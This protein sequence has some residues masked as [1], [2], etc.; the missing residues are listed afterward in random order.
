MVYFP[1]IF[2]S[3]L[4]LFQAMPLAAFGFVYIGFLSFVQS[5]DMHRFAIPVHAIA[6]LIGCHFFLSEKLVKFVLSC[7][8]PVAFLCE[9]YYCSQQIKSRQMR[10]IMGLLDAALG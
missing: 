2:G 5:L 8:I 10:K 9:L 3:V 1:A 7:A 6:L 4:L